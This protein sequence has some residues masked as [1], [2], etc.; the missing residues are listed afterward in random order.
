MKRRE[1]LAGIASAVAWGLTKAQEP[2]KISLGYT[3]A[4]DFATVFVAAQQG[5]FGSSGLDVELVFVPINSTIPAAIQADSLQLGGPTA[6]VFLQSVDGGL[7]HVVIAG[8]AVTSKSSL[9]A[10]LVARAG[11]GIRSARD[12]VGKVIGVPGLGAF[13]HVTLRAWLKREG[14]DPRG[15]SFAETPFSAQGDLLRAGTVAAVA[16]GEPMLSRIVDSGVGYVASYYTSFLPDG[17][18]TILYSARRDWARDHAEAVHRFQQVLK[19][20]AGYVAD[21][22]NAQRVRAIIGR[23]IKLPAQ[24]LA[25]APILPPGP[26]IT[27]KQLAFWIDMLQDQEMLK[28]RLDPAKLLFR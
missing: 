28:G 7:D 14:V 13:L 26:V 11:S 6:S 9:A 15:V 10:G 12:C 24:V 27:Q 19:T 4:S 20:A 22:A 16:T 23:Y 3:A 25:K 2:T 8:A 5:L 1:L 21:P 18:P 17:M